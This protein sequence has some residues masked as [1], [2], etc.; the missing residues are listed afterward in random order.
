MANRGYEEV[1][2]ALTST[3]GRTT[4]S[5]VA[6][7]LAALTAAGLTMT[8]RALADAP[9]PAP[10]CA[11]PALLQFAQ[12]TPVAIPDGSS[13]ESQIVVSGAPAVLKDV[14]VRTFIPHNFSSDLT[15][16]LI[17]PQ[18]TTVVLKS[19]TTSPITT[20]GDPGSTYGMNGV[21]DGTIWDDDAT[22]AASD[23]AYQQNTLKQRV[24]PEGSLGA[25]IGEDPNGTWKLRAV[26]VDGTG[27]TGTISSWSLS[28]SAA[29]T[30]PSSTSTTVQNTSGAAISASG[31]PTVTQTL[32]V[33]G[34]KYLTDVDL[35]TS[36][37]H[38]FPGDLRISLTSPA[39]TTVLIS[40]REGGGTDTVF[41][42]TVWDDGT[43]GSV[44]FT[45]KQ[46]DFSTG[47][48]SRL[49]PEGA[50]AAF[51]GEDPNGTWTLTIKDEEAADGGSL[52]SWGLTVRSTDGCA[53]PTTPT[54]PT[55]TTPT[56]PTLP[57]PT[58]PAKK[59]LKAL[60]LSASVTRDRT[61]PFAFPL[62][63]RLNLP[64]GVACSG[65]V[66]VTA[67]AGKKTLRTATSSVKR[68]RG[69]CTYKATIRFG[70]RPA[71]LPANGKVKLTARFLG[72]RTLKAKASRSVTV[73]LG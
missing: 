46:A 69:A 41:S 25:F 37:T 64:S 23:T 39:G 7:S 63:G 1:A 19:Q 61:A 52:T 2:V 6:V 28:L 56:T 32:N 11:V 22:E 59:A 17:S 26:D 13:A 29:G 15:I 67:T 66:R 3:P 60:G 18:G 10:N 65:K 5:L 12:S 38:Q 33:S 54:T 49:V 31:T 58:N 14:D 70:K 51:I 73:R 27:G 21:F 68:Q 48:Q 71:A 42:G 16:T 55:P 57:G 30:T 43:A 53:T 35:T 47:L 50:L 20:P 45:V 24:I 36:I 44:P 34:A 62:S 9:G 40:G 8:E 72:T 4:R